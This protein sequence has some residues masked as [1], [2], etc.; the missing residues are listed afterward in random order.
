MQSTL[1]YITAKPSVF[2]DDGIAVAT[3]EENVA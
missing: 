3:R 2:S 1:C